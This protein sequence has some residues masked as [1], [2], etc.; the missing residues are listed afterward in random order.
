M[1]ES[2]QSPD[3]FDVSHGFA[4]DPL[5]CVD[6]FAA[7]A[8]LREQDFGWRPWVGQALDPRPKNADRWKERYWDG[9]VQYLEQFVDS[10]LCPKFADLLVGYLLVIENESLGRTHQSRAPIGIT[11]RASLP[12]SGDAKSLKRLRRIVGPLLTSK[13]QRK[14]S[15]QLIINGIFVDKLVESGISRKD[16]CEFHLPKIWAA[17]GIEVNTSFSA[18]VLRMDRRQR[19]KI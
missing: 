4:E 2:G 1:S 16:G 8:L 18:S 3:V 5:R 19:N 15:L 12:V 13:P 14:T 6:D 10:E 9:L 17:V 7:R 11:R